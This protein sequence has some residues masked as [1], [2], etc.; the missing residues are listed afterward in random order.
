[1]S[2]ITRMRKQTAVYWALEHNE[3]G[4]IAYDDYGQPQYADPVEI[5]DDVRWS[6]KIVQFI[7]FNGSE[8]MSKSKVFV[9]RDMV[10]SEV[11]ML[12]SLTDVTDLTN[13][14]ENDGAW[15]IRGFNKVP[16]FKATE[17]LRTAFL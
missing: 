8:Q 15:E 14:K 10:A 13:P 5:T 12:G 3:S 7:D 1:M 11:L 6:N 4:G 16:N 2:I 17:F 9:D